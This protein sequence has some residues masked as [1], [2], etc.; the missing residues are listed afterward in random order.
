MEGKRIKETN[1]RSVFGFR[2]L[3]IVLAGRKDTRLGGQEA[4]KLEGS[5]LGNVEA[6]KLKR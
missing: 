3:E 2:H 6:G 4:G 5:R 1:R